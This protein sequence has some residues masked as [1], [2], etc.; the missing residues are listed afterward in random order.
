LRRSVLIVLAGLVRVGV[1]AQLLLD[2]LLTLRDLLRVL[3]DFL[4]RL[5]L[6]LVGLAHLVF[7]LV[8]R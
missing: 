7:L 1:H 8:G 5:V 6:E 4:L 3:L 2:A